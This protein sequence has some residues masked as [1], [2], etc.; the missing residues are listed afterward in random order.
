MSRLPDPHPAVRLLALIALGV[1]LFR[2]SLPAL[3]AVLALLVGAVGLSGG[4]DGLAALSRALR[5]IRWLL[6]S[7]L[8]IYLLVAPEPAADGALPSLTDLALALR[9]V[10]VLV[11]LVTAVELLRQTTPASRTAAALVQILGPLAWAGVD[12]E[13]F[14]RRVALTLEAVPAT[15]ETVGRAAGRV[16]IKKGQLRGWAEAAAALIRDIETGT[17]GPA[18]AAGLPV[19]GPPRPVDWLLL[20]GVFFVLYGLLRLVP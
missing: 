18:E 1:C 5:R 7:I 2:L 20:G 15:A 3:A 9:R 8:I 6:L 12:T 10:G 14:A 13:R 4:R 11:V 16:T 19:L 17:G